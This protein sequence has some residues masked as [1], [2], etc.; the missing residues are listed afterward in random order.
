MTSKSWSG[1]DKLAEIE[2]RVEVARDYD[3]SVIVVF[4]GEDDSG[5]SFPEPNEW[6]DS[7]TF[8]YSLVSNRITRSLEIPRS[9][10]RT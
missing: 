8:L 2:T 9:C 4:F 5:A 10:N 1:W 6:R 7:V 3:N